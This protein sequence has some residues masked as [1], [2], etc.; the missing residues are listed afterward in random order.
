MAAS[1]VEY[2]T[3][4]RD[5][6][7]T[8]SSDRYAAVPVGVTQLGQSR[9]DRFIIRVS[10]RLSSSLGTLELCHRHVLPLDPW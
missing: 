1:P 2:S 6:V 4:T 9:D 5:S 7:G 10:G 8:V 3:V